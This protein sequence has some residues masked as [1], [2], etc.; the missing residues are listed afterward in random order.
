MGDLAETFRW[1]WKSIGERCD[2]LMYLRVEPR[3]G[4]LVGNPEFVRAM[5]ALHR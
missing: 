4:K 1:G 3:V 5:A 2:Y